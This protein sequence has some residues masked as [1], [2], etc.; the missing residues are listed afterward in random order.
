MSHTELIRALPKAELHVHIEGT[1]EPELMFEIAQRNQIDIPYKSVEEVR[2]AY[3]FHNL[4]S[5]LDIYYAGA[6]V[7]IHE[8]DFYDLAWAYFKKCAEDHVVHTEIF[9]DPQTHTDRGIAF[10]TVL[11]GLQ[12]ACN[13]AKTKL[14]ISSYLIM[15]F[16]RHLSEEAALKTLEQALP[17]KNQII[18]VGLDSSEVGHPPAK[19]TRVFAKAREAGFLVVA[20][21]GEEGPP[22]Y[23][24]EA[25]DL[26][27]V[28]RIDHGVRSEEDPVLMQRLIQEKM[29]LT[30]CPL[31]NL[32]LCVVDDMQQHNIHRLLQQGVKVT[33]NSD[34]PSYFGGYMNDNF[35]AIQK[36]LN[37]SEAELK[38]LAINSFEAAFIDNT[39]KQSWIKKIQAL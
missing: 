4:Q 31:S 18:A 13:D 38:Q 28:N 17:Y 6:N 29:P 2:Q 16:L 22:E 7:L 8:E 20:H 15:C 5:F 14:G 25:L 10:E 3:N 12:R 26:L 11:N 9:F 35:F 19:F 33:V 39:E 30:V 36:A 1:F 27:K 23:V 24:W 21:A 37:L 34:D 32:K